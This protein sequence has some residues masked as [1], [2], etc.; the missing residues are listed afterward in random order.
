MYIVEEAA[1]KAVMI[2]F[3]MVAG[4][5]RLFLSKAQ[6]QKEGETSRR[7]PQRGRRPGMGFMTQRARPDHL[8]PE[9]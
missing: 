8:A 5:S 6:Q 2:D 9:Q 3:G 7:Q 1:P 4:P